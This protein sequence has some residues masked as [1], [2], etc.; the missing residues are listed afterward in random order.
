[1][2]CSECSVTRSKDLLRQCMLAL[3]APRTVAMVIASQRYNRNTMA[4]QMGRWEGKDENILEQDNSKWRVTG[5]ARSD[6]AIS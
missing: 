5:D 3:D 1:M 4:M 2:D 6:S